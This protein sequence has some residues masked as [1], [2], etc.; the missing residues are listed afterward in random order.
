MERAQEDAY[1]EAIENYRAA[2]QTRISKSSRINSS[3]VASVLP[4]R[5]ISNYFLQFRKVLGNNFQF[6]HFSCLISVIH[7]PWKYGYVL[8]IFRLQIIHCW[9]DAFSQMTMLSV[10]LKCCIQKVCLALNVQWKE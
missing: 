6:V 2:S 10:L 4:R 8:S 3:N 1:K 9:L 5:Q 7:V